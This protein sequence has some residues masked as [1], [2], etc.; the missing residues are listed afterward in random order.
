MRLYTPAN[1]L[2]L[3]SSILKR[4]TE[5]FQLCFTNVQM[6]NALHVYLIIRQPK[7]EFAPSV[8]PPLLF[9]TRGVS[10]NLTVETAFSM[11][12]KPVT[13]EIL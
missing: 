4:F 9:R 1:F 7:E 11:E 12:Q 8:N 2:M 13:M 3:S 5:L 6:S 10:T